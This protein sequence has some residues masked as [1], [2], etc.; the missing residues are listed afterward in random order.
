MDLINRIDEATK[1]PSFTEYFFDKKNYKKLEKQFRKYHE[2]SAM[3]YGNDIVDI[4]QKKKE[5]LRKLIHQKLMIIMLILWDTKQS[6]MQ[7]IIQY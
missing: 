2:D 7:L 4:I 5:N 6:G 1:K 3:E